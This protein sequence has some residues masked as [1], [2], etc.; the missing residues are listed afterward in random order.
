M[1]RRLLN[2]LTALSLLLCV[3]VCGLWVRSRSYRDSFEIWRARVTSEGIVHSQV[4]ADSGGG[5]V[6]LSAGT[7]LQPIR[8][9]AAAVER[10][11]QKLDDGK[12][13]GHETGPYP[14]S[15]FC[16]SPQLGDNPPFGFSADSSREGAGTR[17]I[18]AYAIPALLSA[19]VPAWR[20]CSGL[21]ACRRKRTGACGRCGYDLRATPD[22]CPECGTPA[23]VSTTA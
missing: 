7:A 18:L 12:R 17:L 21:G 22:R 3:A 19:A 23:T 14:E 13:W 10:L 1:L 2:L 6:V 8:L 5:R 20:T 4:S 16:K 11:Q 15:F 9:D